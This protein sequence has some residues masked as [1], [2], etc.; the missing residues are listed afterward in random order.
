MIM[1]SLSDNKCKTSKITQF[2][3]NS[4]KLKRQSFA[5]TENHYDFVNY[6]RY[7]IF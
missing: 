6:N 2:K 3:I 7:Q 5:F 4:N 1:I